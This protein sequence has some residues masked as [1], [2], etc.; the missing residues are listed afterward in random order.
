MNRFKLVRIWCK[1]S[2]HCDIECFEI[3]KRSFSDKEARFLEKELNDL[4]LQG[5]IELCQVKPKYISP[6]NC[7]SKKN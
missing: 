5:Y 6:I 7:A 1:L 4:L 2:F 3:V